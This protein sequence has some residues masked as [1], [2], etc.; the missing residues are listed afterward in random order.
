MTI[1][2]KSRL[3]GNSSLYTAVLV[4]V[5]LF[6]PFIFKT[7]LLPSFPWMLCLSMPC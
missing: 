2:S 4:L 1:F 6:Q 5:F 3:V 7:F